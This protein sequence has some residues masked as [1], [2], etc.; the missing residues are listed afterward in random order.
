MNSKI[1][2]GKLVFPYEWRK[3]KGDNY[4]EKKVLVGKE[5]EEWFVYAD[6]LRREEVLDSFINYQR[7]NGKGEE[8]LNRVGAL[9]FTKYVKRIQRVIARAGTNH[10]IKTV[11]TLLLASAFIDVDNIQDQ[12][13]LIKGFDSE[14]WSI[15][16]VFPVYSPAE[17]V[18]NVITPAI[19]K[20]DGPLGMVM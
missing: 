18:M 5:R 1:A 2:D 6:R 11:L 9:M 13:A 17:H 8:F 15:T 20:D 4:P 14:G 19:I 7:A 10:P 3:E 12:Q 16:N